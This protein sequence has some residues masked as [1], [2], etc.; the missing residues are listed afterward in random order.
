MHIQKPVHGALHPPKSLGCPKVS[1]GS[2]LE[3]PDDLH[4]YEGMRILHFN[5]VA[6]KILWPQLQFRVSS[7]VET[8]FGPRTFSHPSTCVPSYHATYLSSGHWSKY[9]TFSRKSKTELLI[10]DMG[11]RS[12]ETTGDLH[13][14]RESD[15]FLNTG[16]VRSAVNSPAKSTVQV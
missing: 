8:L 10:T 1:G 14:G 11:A 6:V 9:G 2:N 15:T 13:R 16:L 5:A 12:R 3:R 4:K 7:V